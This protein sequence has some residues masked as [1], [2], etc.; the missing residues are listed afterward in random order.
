M[1]VTEPA[2][3]TIGWFEA[4]RLCGAGRFLAAHSY[5]G[6]RGAPRAA[7]AQDLR[8]SASMASNQEISL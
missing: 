7:A 2:R 8:R 3:M 1:R 6:T 4:S 5:L